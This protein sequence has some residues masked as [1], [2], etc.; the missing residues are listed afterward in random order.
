MPALLSKA[1]K[2]IQDQDEE[3]LEEGVFS[4]FIKH[5][6]RKFI[7][8]LSPEGR[9][10]KAEKIAAAKE[11]LLNDYQRIKS[12]QERIKA[13]SAALDSIKTVV[14]DKAHLASVEKELQSDFDD[15]DDELEEK[16]NN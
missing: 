16:N 15:I 2:M 8:K 10:A 12:A 3:E 13:A 7:H 6:I 14:K 4:N 5:S 11:K 9:A 1:K